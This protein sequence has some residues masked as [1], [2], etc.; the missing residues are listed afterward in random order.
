MENGGKVVDLTEPRLTHIIIDKRDDSRRLELMKRTS[1]SVL[2][3]FA[4]STGANFLL[5]GPR[6][7]TLLFL[8]SFTPVWRR[9]RC[10]MKKVCVHDH[11][12][13]IH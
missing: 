5:Q 8:N 4:F 12:V 9:R 13:K 2:T 11:A 10:S 6:G 3:D 7:V 1:K